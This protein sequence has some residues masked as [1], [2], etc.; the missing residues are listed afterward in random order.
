L[1][2]IF[3]KYKKTHGSKPKDFWLKRRKFEFFKTLAENH[4]SGQ[5]L[6]GIKKI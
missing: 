5:N 2:E 3:N 4:K 1:A 6:A